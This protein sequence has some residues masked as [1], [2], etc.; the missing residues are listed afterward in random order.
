MK[1]KRKSLG[2]RHTQKQAKRYIEIGK[3]PLVSASVTVADGAKVETSGAA[4]KLL[5]DAVG[6]KKAVEWHSKY[7]DKFKALTEKCYSELENLVKNAKAVKEGE[8]NTTTE[9]N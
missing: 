8:E 4:I 1:R 9:N 2:L 3:S 5:C 7:M 6:E